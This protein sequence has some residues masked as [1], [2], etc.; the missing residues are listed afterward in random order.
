M[1]S[2]IKDIMDG[3]TA[4]GRKGIKVK[5]KVKVKVEV[6]V[7]INFF[8]AVEPLSHCA[9]APFITLEFRTRNSLNTFFKLAQ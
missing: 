8:L 3:T 2:S 6:E 4:Q 7:E 9:V 1:I 5:V